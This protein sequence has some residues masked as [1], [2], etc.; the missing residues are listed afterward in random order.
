VAKCD[1]FVCLIGRIQLEWDIRLSGT[2]K[3]SNVNLV[4][5]GIQPHIISMPKFSM[6]FANR[7]K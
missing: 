5:C 4:L 3:V 1:C 7:R 2:V 6:V